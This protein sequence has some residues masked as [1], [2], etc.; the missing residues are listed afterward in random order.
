[1]DESQAGIKVSR[2][3]INNLTLAND[4]TH[5]AE[6]EEEIKSCLMKVQEEN[7]K[8]DLKTQHSENQDHGIRPNQFMA[9][10]W[11][12]NGNNDRLYF[13]GLQNHCIW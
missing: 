1:M 6:N 7:E 12:N 5:M 10:R 3:N 11:R 2:R 13:G 9:N 8:V 4:T